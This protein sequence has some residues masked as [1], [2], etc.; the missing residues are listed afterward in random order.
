M[1][2][3]KRFVNNVVLKGGVFLA[4]LAMAAA[5]FAANSACFFPYYEPEQPEEL[6]KLKNIDLITRL[7]E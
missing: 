4:A 3:V 5:T 2:K 7:S 6:K 1:A